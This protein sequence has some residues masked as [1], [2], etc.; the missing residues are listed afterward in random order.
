[1][2]GILLSIIKGIKKNYAILWLG[3]AR[4]RTKLQYGEKVDSISLN[5]MH[6]VGQDSNLT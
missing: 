1:V 3:V 4:M 5:C 6:K 2:L